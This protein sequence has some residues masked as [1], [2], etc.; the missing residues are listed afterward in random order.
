[1]TEKQQTALAR[2][3]ADE[4]RAGMV[5]TDQRAA[6]LSRATGIGE[7]H[8]S[9]LL[10]GQRAGTIAAWDSLLRA[11]WTGAGGL[12]QVTPNPYVVDAEE[13]CVEILKEVGI[14]AATTVLEPP[15]TPVEHANATPE[16]RSMVPNRGAEIAARL[17]AA[18][19]TPEKLKEAGIIDEIRPPKL[20]RPI[21]NPLN[22]RR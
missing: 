8:I 22:P 20:K 10:R 17:N 7:P 21:S 15:Y 9:L 1:M 11:A 2:R 3:L 12:H 4:V 19:I 5:R 14:S 18:S 16:G 13:A 6:D